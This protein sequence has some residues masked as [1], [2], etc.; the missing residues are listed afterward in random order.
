MEKREPRPGSLSTVISPPIIWQNFLL[1]ANPKPV[2][3]YFR[4]AEPS[5]CEKGWNSLPR[6]SRPI[7]MPVS[8]TCTSVHS[9]SPLR[10][11]FTATE[12]RPL[13][14]NFR[15]LFTRFST[16]CRNLERSAEASRACSGQSI[17]STLPCCR[18]SGWAALRTPCSAPETSMLCGLTGSRPGPTLRGAV[19]FE[20]L[21]LLP[22]QWL[23]TVRDILQH[24]GDNDALRL[25]RLAAGL[26]LGQIQDVVDNAQQDVA[27]AL[28]LLQVGE[29][30]GLFG[31]DAVFA[32]HLAVADDGVQRRAQFV[33]HVGE[34]DALG[35]IGILGGVPR[36]H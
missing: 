16:L 36:E 3:L 24:R 7:P 13:S 34:E 21:A 6:C 28:D 19:D 5:T 22:H 25:D 27:G 14:V 31:P 10:T 1:I 2:P 11:L 33:T 23:D 35:P 20:H 18:N 9:P 4:V 26:D 29:D 17:S 32:Q 12:T 8:E 30:L 15:A